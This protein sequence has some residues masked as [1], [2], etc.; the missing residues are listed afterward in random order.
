MPPQFHTAN[1]RPTC[2]VVV[3]PGERGARIYPKG[4]K[5]RSRPSTNRPNKV[6]KYT[7]DGVK[8]RTISIR[9]EEYY[10]ICSRNN[11]RASFMYDTGASSIIMDTALAKKFDILDNN[12]NSKIFGA[13]SKEY[14]DASNRREVGLEVPNV[15]VNV[16][17]RDEDTNELINV[18]IRTKVGIVD[19][20]AFL[21]GVDA[22]KKLKE[23]GVSFK[24]K[25]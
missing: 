24:L 1:N 11:K 8:K 14:E 18:K 23:K 6:V 21:F 16:Q 7:K 3:K 9:G 17:L 4:C 22:I 10:M 5:V 20:S 12:G 25:N 19:E 13:I 2:K 15:D